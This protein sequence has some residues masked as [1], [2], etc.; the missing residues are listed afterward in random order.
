MVKKE[1][2]TS[3]KQWQ[4]G[5]NIIKE[6]PIGITRRDI[7]YYWTSYRSGYS[8]FERRKKNII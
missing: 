5:H 2:I 4:R 1:D 6:K 3:G 7:W 8:L